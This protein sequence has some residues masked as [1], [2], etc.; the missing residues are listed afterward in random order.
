MYF[1]LPEKFSFQSSTSINFVECMFSSSQITLKG[2]QKNEWMASLLF[3]LKIKSSGGD[4]FLNINPINFF[5]GVSQSF[6][7]VVFFLPSI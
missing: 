7:S 5:V 4:F 1:P 6:T 3:L 2:L